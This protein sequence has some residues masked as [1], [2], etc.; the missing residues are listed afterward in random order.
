MDRLGGDR[1]RVSVLPSLRIEN[2]W[3]PRVT[4]EL[5]AG[6]EWSNEFGALGNGQDLGF[7][8][9]AGYRFDY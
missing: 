3:I 5:E 8:G 1:Q 9:L 4:L 6:L 7:F 2:T